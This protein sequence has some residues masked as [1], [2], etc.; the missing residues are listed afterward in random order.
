MTTIALPSVFAASLLASPVFHVRFWVVHQHRGHRVPPGPPEHLSEWS[1]GR[2]HRAASTPFLPTWFSRDPNFL[3]AAKLLA[4]GLLVSLCI[5][6]RRF[7]G[8]RPRDVLAAPSG[9]RS[10]SPEASGSRSWWAGRIG[11]PTLRGEPRSSRKE[12]YSFLPEK[13]NEK[14]WL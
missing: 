2:R 6:P 3:P 11:D 10:V 7:S 12:N 5:F 1:P 9:G 4:P 8:G 13:C 14:S